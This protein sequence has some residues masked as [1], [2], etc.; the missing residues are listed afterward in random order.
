VQLV[1]SGPNAG[2]F[3]QSVTIKDHLIA[4]I[5]D[6]Y[7][8]GEGT[9]DVNGNWLP[10][11]LGGQPPARWVDT[12]CHRSANAGPAQAAL[13]LEAA[14]PH[15]T[16]TFLSFACSGATINRNYNAGQPPWD[17]YDPG[18]PAKVLGTGVL[19][20]YR[21]VEPV[22]PDN[23]NDKVPDQI[24]ELART[25]QNRRIDAL[26]VSGGGNDMGFGPLAGACVWASNCITDD[27]FVT[28]ANGS[29][30]VRVPT[31]FDQDMALIA[32]R[33]AALDAAIDNP[34]PAGRPALRVARTFITQYPDSTT[35]RVNGQ[36]VT[37]D[38]IL[39]DIAWALGSK[40]S[41]SEVTFARNTVLPRMNGA[42]AAAA[43]AHGWEVV[44]EHVAQSAGHGYCVGTSDQPNA[45][46]WIRTA[47][48]AEVLQ[49]PHERSKTTGTLHPTRRGYQAYADA[50]V[51]RLQ[52]FLAGLPVDNR[53]PTVDAGADQSV[54]KFTDFVLSASGSDPENRPMTY[55]WVQLSGPAAVIRS[56][57][58]PRTEVGGV[59]GKN[60]LVFQVTATD[61]NGQVATDTVTVS[62]SK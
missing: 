39:E 4:S 26:V 46:R 53:P 44:T 18:D 3:T 24:S 45:D 5:G 11:P 7:G 20:P 42:V 56:P 31:R 23:Y 9:P 60:T 37:C 12:R 21:G 57:N 6:S 15:S 13:R 48:E 54:A 27:Y 47:A 62:V 43:G 10:G 22:N 33:Y 1:I 32:G 2:S 35:E 40:M 29:G 28:S 50:L 16:V 49:G 19:G 52:P 51:P 34:N 58:S 17:P 61:D 30:P 55:R 38:E 8:S 59:A 36:V 41:G 14:D 25:V